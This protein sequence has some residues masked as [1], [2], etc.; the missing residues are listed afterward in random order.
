MEF[1]KFTSISQDDVMNIYENIEPN[2]D[3]T[4][5]FA[6][7]KDIVEPSHKLRD[8]LDDIS[9]MWHRE[10]LFLIFHKLKEDLEK[11]CLQV[12]EERFLASELIESGSWAEQSFFTTMSDQVREKFGKKFSVNKG[13]VTLTKKTS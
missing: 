10:N 11:A 12:N 8:Q 2:E 5:D 1:K 13:Q 4:T 6:S 9:S 3:V 7:G